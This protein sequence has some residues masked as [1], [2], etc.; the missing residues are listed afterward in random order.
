M[1]PPSKGRSKCAMELCKTLIPVQDSPMS[2]PPHEM[3]PTSEMPLVQDA[4]NTFRASYHIQDSKPYDNVSEKRYRSCLI[5]GR[6][7]DAVKMKMVNNY[8]RLS[9]PPDEPE[10]ITYLRR[11]VY[12]NVLNAETL[13]FKTPAVSLP[14]V[15]ALNSQLQRT[16]RK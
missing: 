9:I 11:E 3:G 16:T 8:M 1:L 2:P 12:L 13:L 6:S 4:S 5:C 10:S 15:T 14:S 7:I